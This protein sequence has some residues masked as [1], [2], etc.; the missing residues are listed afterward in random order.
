M[1]A[2]N[3]YVLTVGVLA[4]YSAQV[5]AITK[6]IDAFEA[7]FCNLIVEVQSVDG[8]QGREKDVVIFSAV[9]ASRDRGIG[10]LQYYERLNV[11]ITRGRSA[12]FSCRVSWSLL[13]Y[14]NVSHQVNWPQILCMDS[15]ECG[16]T[17]QERCLEFLDRECEGKKMLHRSR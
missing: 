14:C 8:L 13:L 12:S 15:R 9:R 2:E 10:F 6:Q 11:A 7:K 17:F 16:H 4:P 1:C 5:Q 3:N